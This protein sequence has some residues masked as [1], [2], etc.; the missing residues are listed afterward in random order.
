MTSACDNN[1]LSKSAAEIPATV[2]IRE[3]LQLPRNLCKPFSQI[4]TVNSS[5]C[6]LEIPVIFEV[7]CTA[8]QIHFPVS[9]AQRICE[10]DPGLNGWIGAFYKFVICKMK[11]I[12]STST[13]Y[14]YSQATS[15]CHSTASFV[16]CMYYLLTIAFSSS[17]PFYLLGV[18][19]PS[20]RGLQLREQCTDWLVGDR[21]GHSNR[22]CDQPGA[23]EEEAIWHHQSWHCGG[24]PPGIC[25]TE[26]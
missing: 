22:D 2:L 20:G 21:S 18:I 15:L 5:G 23:F 16:S 3:R 7:N 6:T 1:S 10:L 24:E 14:Y 11:T 26:L 19:P 8:E 4:Q 17:H 12:I 25:G 13:V 9:L